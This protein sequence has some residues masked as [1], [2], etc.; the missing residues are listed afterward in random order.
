MSTNRF[1]VSVPRLVGLDDNLIPPHGGR[2]VQAFVPAAERMGHLQY[3]DT[4]PRI[5]LALSELHDLEMLACGAYSPLNGF[6]DRTT[7]KAVCDSMRLANGLPWGVPVTL[8]ISE[9]VSR[10][11]EIGGHVGLFYGSNAVAIMTVSDI[12]PWNPEKETASIWGSGHEDPVVAERNA[13]DAAFLVGGPVAFFAARMA[14]HLMPGHMWPRETRSMFAMRGWKRMST[15]HMQNPWHRAQE[16]HLKCAL[17]SSDGLLLLRVESGFSSPGAMPEKVLADASQLLLKNYFPAD[18][19]LINPASA[20]VSARHER[21]AIQHAILA[22]NYGCDRIFFAQELDPRRSNSIDDRLP[23]IFAVAKSAGL[24]IAPDF[25]EP[26]FHCEAC[27]GVATDKS[28]PHDSSLRVFISETELHEKLRIGENLPTMAARPDVARALSRG[29]SMTMESGAII[30]SG[31]HIFP[32]IGEVSRDLRQAIAGHRACVLWMTGLS[33]SGKSTI[34]HRLEREL[35]MSGHRVYVLDGDT[36]R[37]GLNKD[38][39][40]SDDARRENLR[41][42]GEVAKVMLEAGIIVIASFISPFRSDREKLREICGKD[43]YEVYVEASLEDCE[44][45]DPKGLYKRARAGLIPQFTGVSSPYEHPENPELQLNTSVYSLDDCVQ[46]SM[47]F[48]A[49]AGVTRSGRKEGA[50]SRNW[51]GNGVAATGINKI[52]IQ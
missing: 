26:A 12:Y 5:Q 23:E 38:L 18:R 52:T 37:N 19:V 32:H 9:E 7:Y 4:L 11:L 17:E 6:M 47:R 39:G 10:A 15:F 45:R 36:L 20:A 31:N 16:Y 27:A 8:A 51:P 25:L 33:G 44:Q 43:F 46:Q 2:L 40:F 3:A 41:R 1:P 30:K 24:R 48:I 50:A 21:A 14:P 28:C 29:V 13:R 34:A 35:L 22:Q 49:D 42:A